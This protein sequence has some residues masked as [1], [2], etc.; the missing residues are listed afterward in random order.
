MKLSYFVLMFRVW[1]SLT[2]LPR[3]SETKMN[4]LYFKVQSSGKSNYL[5]TMCKYV[6]SWEF[7][8]RGN[9]TISEKIEEN[10]RKD[11]R[12]PL[13][14]VQQHD[15]KQM[16]GLWSLSGLSRSCNFSELKIRIRIATFLYFMCQNVEIHENKILTQSWRGRLGPDCL[17]KTGRDRGKLE[18]N[19]F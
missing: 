15:W 9:W 3:S 11:Q 14:S 1:L 4:S 12:S 10:N 13:A 8:F 2:Y 6:W 17:G 18:T 19:V 7:V 16:I 5:L